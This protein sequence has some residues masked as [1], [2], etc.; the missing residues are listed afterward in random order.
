MATDP[1]KRATFIESTVLHLQEFGFE[2]VDLD[3]EYPGTGLGTDEN[4]DM[5][6]FSALVD[7]FKT[8]LTPYGLLLTAALSPGYDKIALAYDVPY[9]FERFDF[10]NIMCYDYHGWWPE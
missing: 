9:I 5:A 2:G 10:A 7:E 1:A 4:T 6:S 3:W 8:A